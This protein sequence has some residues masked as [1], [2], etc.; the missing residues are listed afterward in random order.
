[1][2]PSSGNE[3]LTDVA[4]SQL[5]PLAEVIKVPRGKALFFSFAMSK[6][7]EKV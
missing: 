1:M 7:G 4:E 6:E 3:Q 2:P 5:R